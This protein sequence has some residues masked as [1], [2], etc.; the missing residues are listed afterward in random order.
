MKKSIIIVLLLA[1]AVAG[2]SKGSNS[3]ASSTPPS[4]SAPASAET[5]VPTP[6]E[7]A[8]TPSESIEP[9]GKKAVL[10]T[11]SMSNMFGFANYEGTRLMALTDGV[12]PGLV[13]EAKL[14]SYDMAIGQGGR[15]LKIRY[16]K[17]QSRTDQDNGRQS[18][19][20]FENIEGDL[21]TVVEGMADPNESYYLVAEEQ[22]DTGALI[23]LKVVDDL[24]MPEEV[25]KKIAEEKGRAIDKGWLRAVTDED[26]R[27]F[28]VQFERQGD[29]MLASLV[30]QEGDR[31]VYMDYPAEYD[32][33]GTW[34]VDDGGDITPFSFLFAAHSEEG[35]V[36]GVQ[37]WGAEGENLFLLASSGE[38]FK[39]TG[40]S[41]GRYLAP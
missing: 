8:E 11:E 33:M 4:P 5:S 32:E 31:Y 17:H 40:I 13:E 16:E 15:T 26:Q 21:Y 34:R 3:G 23:Q 12:D 18:G 9:T 25:A 1:L 20:N 6:T 35:I 19:Q 39:E 7:P 2:C 28:V 24:E 36:L 14:K 27:I 41:S 10:H 37:W 38:R 30:W 29:Q 22:F